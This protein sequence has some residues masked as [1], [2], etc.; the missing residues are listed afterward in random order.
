VVVPPDQFRHI[1]DGYELAGWEFY[2]SPLSGPLAPQHFTP[3]ELIHDFL[4]NPYLFWRGMSPLSVAMLA[5]QTD[6]AS[7]Q[8][9]KGLMLNNADTGVIVRTDQQ[10]APEQ[11]E[12]VLAAL[13]ARKSSA[14]TA[15]R[16]L[17][18]WGGAEVVKPSL[19]SA[20][21]Q[22]LE[23]RKFNRQEI[24][25]A[26]FRMPQSLV[27]FTEDANRAIHQSERLNFIE[28]SITPFCARL[29]AAVEPIVKAFGPDLFGWFDMD[30]LP[31]LQQA[32][33]DRVDTGLKLFG[34]GYPPNAINKS[35]DLGLPHLNWGDT[36]YLSG[37]L[38]KAGTGT[39]VA[40]STDPN[41]QS[42]SPIARILAKLEDWKDEAKPS[43][44]ENSGAHTC[45]AT[46]AFEALAKPRIK[47]KRVK[48]SGFFFDQR[49]RFLD[50]LNRAQASSNSSETMLESL[51]GLWDTD[52][53]TK[54]L[55]K[56][57][58]PLLESD[59][60]FGFR[61]VAT[62]TGEA[63]L[64]LPAEKLDTFLVQFTTRVKEVNATTREELLSAFRTESETGDPPKEFT[65]RAKAVFQAASD[66]RAERIAESQTY[67]AINAGRF[68]GMVAAGVEKKSWQ[69]VNDSKVRPAH[70]QAE[71][72]YTEGIAVTEP[73]IVDGEPLMYPGDPSG[74]PANTINCRCWTL[75][76]PGDP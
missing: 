33:R 55:V 16:P 65:E 64:V 26:L 39:E 71:L 30:S 52:A 14:G 67:C 69:T 1:V 28:N 40:P 59:V 25:A 27:G 12:Q 45:S 10:L 19:S 34:L 22:F 23:H 21:M 15:D 36:G 74:S 38:Q 70:A 76:L 66:S 6:Y 68:F 5:A 7:A 73:F 44:P 42:V 47:Q 37:T 58:T 24:C 3:D 46:A 54:L 29:E 50:K 18:L 31:I 61:Q 2:S 35:L 9:M 17:L 56:K 51:P 49:K 41:R 63:A 62:E 60:A 72:D 75:S 8:F 32:R 43:I 4:P 20:D 53:E 48:L 13:R 57:L 11:R